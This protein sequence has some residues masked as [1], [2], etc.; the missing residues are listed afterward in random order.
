MREPQAGEII[1]VSERGLTCRG[2]ISE[3]EI[4]FAKEETVKYRLHLK[5]FAE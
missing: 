2:F 3:V 1:E 4:A 5:E